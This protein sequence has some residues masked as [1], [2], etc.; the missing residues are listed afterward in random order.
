VPSGTINDHEDFV[1]QI[2]I[3]DLG[4]ELVTAQKPVALLLP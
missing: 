3:G 4:K 2:F 1:A